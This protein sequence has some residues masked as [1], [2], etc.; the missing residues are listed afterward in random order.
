MSLYKGKWFVGL[1]VT[2]PRLEKPFRKDGIPNATTFFDEHGL[3]VIC[4]GL[5]QQ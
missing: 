1:H 2:D 3:D 4:L 5:E